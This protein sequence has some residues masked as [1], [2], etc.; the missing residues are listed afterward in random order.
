MP[1]AASSPYD[2]IAH[3]VCLTAVAHCDTLLQIFTDPVLSRKHGIDPVRVRERIPRLKK[4]RD[5]WQAAADR[6]MYQL[7]VPGGK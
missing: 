1:E 7:I 2:G 3:E 4:L 6:K 5:E